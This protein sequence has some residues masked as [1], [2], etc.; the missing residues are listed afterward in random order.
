MGD[1]S[2]AANN[3]EVVKLQ[4]ELTRYTLRLDGLPVYDGGDRRTKFIGRKT[5]PIIRKK[6]NRTSTERDFS[7]LTPPEPVVE[8]SAGTTIE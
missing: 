4:P 7:G 5:E 1:P 8:A 2:P 6:S 3:I